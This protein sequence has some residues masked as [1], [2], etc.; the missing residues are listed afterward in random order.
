ML[1]IYSSEN[2]IGLCCKLLL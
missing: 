1:F 2:I